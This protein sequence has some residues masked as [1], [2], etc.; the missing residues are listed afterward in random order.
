M[1]PKYKRK[2]AKAKAKL[3]AGKGKTEIGTEE[4]E[5]RAR[6]F[7]GLSMPDQE[8]TPED[9]YL[10]SREG[11]EGKEPAVPVDFSMDN[12]MAELEA[13]SRAGGGG[14]RSRPTADDFI[15]GEP[16][17]KRPRSD[18]RE[19]DRDRGGY[20]RDS[21]YGDRDRGYD[22]GRERERDGAQG[23]RD[24]GWAARGGPPAPR[25]RDT[26]DDRRDDRGGG[27]RGR[28]G[29]DDTPLQY[30]IYNGRVTS[31]KPFG[32]FVALDGVAG[33]VEGMSE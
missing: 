33:R 25:D 10:Q 4:Q 9:K 6:K 5:L 31:V 16:S 14:G 3:A 29:L 30:K 13:A 28:P 19:R 15:E 7:P 18:E 27:Y 21:G 2:A 22:R 17:A 32:A 20:G 12:T 24:N 1:H 23:V 11:K 26:R 8:W